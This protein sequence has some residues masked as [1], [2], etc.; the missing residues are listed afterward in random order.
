MGHDTVLW[1]READVVAAVNQQ[2]ENVTFLKVCN[3]RAWRAS[4]AAVSIWHSQ[5][6]LR[7]TTHPF[8]MQNACFATCA[9]SLRIHTF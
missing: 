1:A 8:V 6:R 5:S 3:A 2:H 7:N 9:S 4:C